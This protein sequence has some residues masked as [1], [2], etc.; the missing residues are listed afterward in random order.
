ME[1]GSAYRCADC[2][3]PQ[4]PP[5]VDLARAVTAATLGLELGAG[6]DWWRPAMPWPEFQAR[7]VVWLLHRD[8]RCHQHAQLLAAVVVDAM[9]RI[10]DGRP[11]YEAS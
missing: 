9:Q 3:A 8:Q 10:G 2:P 11:Q 1:T 4:I 6:G 7:A 5:L